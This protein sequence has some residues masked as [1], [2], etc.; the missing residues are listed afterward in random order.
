MKSHQFRCQRT[1]RGNS[2]R[3]RHLFVERLEDR[4]LPALVAAYGF[5][6]GQGLTASDVSGNGNTG[7]LAGP[8]WNAAGR[9]GQALSFDGINDWITVNDSNSLDLTTGMTLEAWVRPTS[10]AN[11]RTVIIKE[12][13]GGE[14]YTLYASDGSVPAAYAN[15]GGDQGIT[16][17]SPLPI[18]TWTHIAATYNNANLR[19]YVN[20]VQVGSRALAG[21]IVVTGGPLRMGGNSVFGGEYFVG[22]ID[23]VRIY[24]H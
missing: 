19:I 17:S 18:N 21:P 4:T 23:E 9:F 12:L 13:G 11:W 10:V 20:G 14:A 8:A 7:T 24:N 22:M 6:E 3:N 15:V 1:V 2:R 16:G 5:N